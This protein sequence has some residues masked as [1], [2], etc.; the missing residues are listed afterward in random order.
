MGLAGLKLNPISAVSM[1]TAVGIGVEFTVHVSFCY[2]TALGT[3]N[4]RLGKTLSH[5]FI[6][7]SGS[8]TAREISHFSGYS[9][10]LQHITRHNHAALLGVRVYHP[11]LLYGKCLQ[12]IPREFVS[13]QV[14]CALVLLGIFNGLALLPVV[15]SLI[16]PTPEVQPNGPDKSHLDPPD[17]YDVGG[18]SA[19]VNE[20]VPMHVKATMV[21]VQPV[22]NHSFRE[23][24]AITTNPILRAMTWRR[25]MKRARMATVDKVRTCRRS[26]TATSPP[27]SVPKLPRRS[28]V[29][30]SLLPIFSVSKCRFSQMREL[31]L[32]RYLQVVL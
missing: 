3:P 28:F 30:R 2:L 10:R 24:Q 19:T 1:I 31:F 9:R 18:K 13:S 23:Q 29:A 15:L 32:L 22:T 8:E 16:G 21:F 11:L 4:E 17:E 7:V 5:M 27:R 12:K 26:S 25:S 6:P 20:N 14:L